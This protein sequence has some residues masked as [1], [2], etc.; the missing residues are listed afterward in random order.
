MVRISVCIATYNGEKYIKEQIDSI[1][2]QLDENDE[3]IVSDDNSTDNTINVLREYNDKRIKIYTNNGQKG[4]TNN[5]QNALTKSNGE[6]IFLC[7]QDDIWNSNKV[8]VVLNYLNSKYDM[9]ISDCVIGDTEL[10]VIEESYFN[11]RGSKAGFWNTVIKPNYLGCCMAFNRSVLNVSI[12]FPK[13]DN[14]LPHDLWLGLIGYAFFNVKT[15]N[16]KLIIYRRHGNNVSD[17]GAKSK[18]NI[19]KK[20]I[21]RFYSI[22]NILNRK[23]N[24]K[25]GVE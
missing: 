2:T 13:R 11:T 4:Y 22:V 19:I 14:Y 17:G 21:I 3:I 6:Y 10:K 9:V 7:D 8:Q 5:F 20:F 16:E 1:I 15:T 18:N 24:L 23:L 25:S 12:P